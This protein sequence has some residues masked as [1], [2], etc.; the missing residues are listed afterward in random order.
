MMLRRV[1]AVFVSALVV[2]V[3][4]VAQPETEKSKRAEKTQKRVYEEDGFI[5][6]T[7]NETQKKCQ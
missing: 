3:R 7:S 4:V 2:T 6:D 1:P 5:T